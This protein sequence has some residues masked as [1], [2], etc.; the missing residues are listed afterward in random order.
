MMPAAQSGAC[1]R[2]SARSVIGLL[3]PR[4]LRSLVA[5]WRGNKIHSQYAALSLP[6]TFDRIYE[7]RLWGGDDHSAL[8]S[9]PGS[10]GRYAQEYCDLLKGLLASHR[11]ES[12]ADLGCGDFNTGKLVSACVSRYIG[13][14]IA[15]KIID[16]NTRAYARENVR[17]L[18][19]DI[20][21]DE[22]PT[23]D[24]AILRQVL[25]HLTNA[26]ANAVLE[27]AL[28]TYALVFVTEHIYIGPGAK[29]N[30]DI[31]HGP[32][33]RVQVKSGL[34]IEQ[35]PFNR[36]AIAVGDITISDNE[37]LRTWVVTNSNAGNHSTVEPAPT[38]R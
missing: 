2:N 14:D 5:S 17:F 36:R 18:Q 22:L 24:A 23:A 1:S 19:A 16:A 33:T 35:P 8:S 37:V 32:G 4:S 13:L 21:N 28:R 26:E 15:Q 6:E 29:P 27:N 7:S 31:S 9:G 11:I 30:V 38:P 10:T 12:L 34:F 25:Q 3:I 20:A